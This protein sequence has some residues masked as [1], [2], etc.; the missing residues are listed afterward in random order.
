MF[1][2]LRG[3]L[4]GTLNA[5]DEFICICKLH[6]WAASL[7]ETPRWRKIIDKWRRRT[8]LTAL[9]FRERVCKSGNVWQS[10][11]AAGKHSAT[12]LAFVASY[13]TFV[14]VCTFHD[15]RGEAT[16]CKRDE[17]ENCGV[18]SPKRA[19]KCMFCIRAKVRVAFYRHHRH[20]SPKVSQQDVG[21]TL[22]SL[23]P[24]RPCISFHALRQCQSSGPLT[25]KG[26]VSAYTCLQG[27]PLCSHSVHGVANLLFVLCTNCAFFVLIR[28]RMASVS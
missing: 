8:P 5:A 16:V 12:L 17:A 9:R 25:P 27:C 18:Y 28:D 21:G 10:V 3:H 19:I 24:F 6:P 15:V 14:F 23:H 11:F 26:L 22:R 1:L 7:L 2:P 13:L 4:N 20:R